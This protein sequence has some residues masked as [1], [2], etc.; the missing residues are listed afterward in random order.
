MTEQNFNLEQ[1]PAPMMTGA[2]ISPDQLYRYALWRIW[3]RQKPPCTFIGLNPSTADATVDD[4]TITRCIGFARDWGHGGLY[5][6]NLFAYRATKRA[7]MKKADDPIGEECDGWLKWACANASRIVCAWGSDGRHQGRGKAV[8]EMLQ[9]QYE[10]H[11]FGLT[12]NQ[13]PIHPLYQ[14]KDQPLILIN[15]PATQAADQ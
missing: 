10:L 1:P 4:P 2:K 7:D 6:V 3:D 14:S 12:S 15:S 9:A 5:M 13:Q 8:M 11:C